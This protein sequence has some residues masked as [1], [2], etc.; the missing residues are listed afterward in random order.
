[1]KLTPRLAH[2]EGIL[3]TPGT[4]ISLR[5]ISCP[6]LSVGLKASLDQPQL[7]DAFQAYYTTNVGIHPSLVSPPAH[8][9]PSPDPIVLSIANSQ[10]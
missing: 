1:M 10:P 7:E 5:S 9:V 4:A 6:P 8:P 2:S 3:S